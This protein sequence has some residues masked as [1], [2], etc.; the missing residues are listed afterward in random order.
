MRSFGFILVLI[1]VQF[2]KADV[3]NEILLGVLRQATA[4]NYT[5]GDRTAVR[6]GF[7]IGVKTE[8]FNYV[9]FTLKLGLMYE[10]RQLTDILAGVEHNFEMYHFDLLTHLSYRVTDSF[11]IYAGPQYSVL[12]SKKCKP[13]TGDCVLN[14]SHASKYFIPMTVG[15][16]FTFIENYGVEIYYEFISQEIWET[17]FEKVQ[18]YGL[19]L[20]YKF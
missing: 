10:Q 16:D 18:T 14:E 19:N 8:S 11:S 7:G 5:T 15:L 1:A 6:P 2:S 13:V 4:Q 17:A 3:H 12:A 9:G 20:K